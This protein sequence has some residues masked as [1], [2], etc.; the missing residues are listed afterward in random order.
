MSWPVWEVGTCSA[1]HF[2]AF[3]SF[4]GVVKSS[5]ITR[6]HCRPGLGLCIC[7]WR[8]DVLRFGL[9]LVCCHFAVTLSAAAKFENL[10]ALP[11]KKCWVWLNSGVKILKELTLCLILSCPV[12]QIAEFLAQLRYWLIPRRMTWIICSNWQSW[13]TF[14][15]LSYF[16][17]ENLTGEGHSVNVSCHTGLVEIDGDDIYVLFRALGRRNCNDLDL[18][19]DQEGR[20]RFDSSRC[21]ISPNANWNDR[22]ENATH[23]SNFH[24]SWNSFKTLFWG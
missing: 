17:N 15:F 9:E 23:Y 16:T 6:S 5:D 14:W 7:R 21:T 22:Q 4:P 11:V 13:G 18:S 12:S 20:E 24:T 8:C 19:V 1:A 10:S 3:S 2:L